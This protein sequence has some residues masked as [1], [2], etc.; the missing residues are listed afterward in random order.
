M[1]D[2]MLIEYRAE[3]EHVERV[4]RALNDFGYDVVVDGKFEDETFK[5]V[6]QFQADNGLKVDGKVGE[7][8]LTALGLDPETLEPLASGDDDGTIVFT[9]QEASD[10]S[11]L[12]FPP[13]SVQKD[14]NTYVDLVEKRHIL[15]LAAM[16]DALNNFETS[17][18]FD[19]EADA[20]PDILG[21][22]ISTSFELGVDA[23]LEN[24]PGA[25]TT[26]KFFDATT[27]ELERAGKASQGLRV[28]QWIQDQRDIL[29]NQTLRD[30]TQDKLNNLRAEMEED[31]LARDSQG[32]QEFRV[33][34]MEANI[35]LSG[36]PSYTVEDLQLRLYE[37]WINAHHETGLSGHIDFELEYDDGEFDLISCH[38]KAPS[39]DNIDTA[40]NRL[41]DKSLPR[42]RF[43]IDLKVQ[44]QVLLKTDAW[45]GGKSWYSAWLDYDNNLSHEQGP[46]E[47]KEGYPRPEWRTMAK[48]FE[49]TISSS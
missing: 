37:Q 35:K 33:K 32:R 38:V 49:G 36:V 4:Q 39:G 17:M 26:K 10:F 27:A 44:K 2:P 23:V 15:L 43:P 11:D 29:S 34:L 18:S 24:L 28:A 20:Q 19:S 41:L 42:F 40:L 9:E 7:D 14:I 3:G 47:A 21:A 6:R 1:E 30:T 12:E 25:S 31:F 22:L 46:G 16:K 45:A 48:R 13:D 5:A 8:T